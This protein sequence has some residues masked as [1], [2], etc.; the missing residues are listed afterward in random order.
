MVLFVG[1]T[2]LAAQNLYRDKGGHEGRLYKLVILDL[3]MEPGFGH[4][5]FSLHRSCR[6]SQSFGC[7]FD[8]KAAED[9]K[10]NHPALLRVNCCQVVERFIQN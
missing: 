6:Y 10:L 4:A 8:C 3:L 7:V 9:A 1:A 2:S 5:P